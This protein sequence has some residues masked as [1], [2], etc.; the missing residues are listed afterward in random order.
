MTAF[1]REAPALEP[2]TPCLAADPFSLAEANINPLTGLSTD[3][4]NHFNEAIML[5]EMLPSMPECREDLAAWR[6]LDYHEHFARSQL[7]QRELAMAAYD[8]ADPRIRRRFDDL[9]E[10]MKSAVLAAQAGLSSEPDPRDAERIAQEATA[11]LKRLVAL[12]SAV[13]HGQELFEGAVSIQASQAAVD[14][15]L[16]P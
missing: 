6:P 5:L 15:I 16:E 7:T 1:P 12:A 8:L 9:C 3:Y 14:A 11:E 2:L 10:G 13:I 4:L